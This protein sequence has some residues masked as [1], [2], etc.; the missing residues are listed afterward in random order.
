MGVPAAI[1]RYASVKA[2][3]VPDYRAAMGPAV[4]SATTRS[5]MMDDGASLVGCVDWYQYG[6][7]ARPDATGPRS[8]PGVQGTVNAVEGSF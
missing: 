4:G 6:H 2:L 7:R 5:I 8:M 1:R 3:S